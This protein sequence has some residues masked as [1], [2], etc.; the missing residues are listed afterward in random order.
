MSGALDYTALQTLVSTLI[1]QAGEPVVLRKFTDTVGSAAWR[2]G[3]RSSVDYTG[4]RGVFFPN[5]IRG[6]YRLTLHKGAD[7][8]ESDVVCYVPGLILPEPLRVEETDVLIR[9]DGSAWRM[10]FVDFLDPAGSVLYY[11]LRVHR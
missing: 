6:P 9:K 7:F 11:E 3:P 10:R 2:P 1:A 8:P 4:Q 5:G